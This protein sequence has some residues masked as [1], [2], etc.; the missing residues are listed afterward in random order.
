MADVALYVHVVF[1]GI[2]LI[3]GAVALTLTKGSPFHRKSGYV[4]AVTMIIMAVP[5]LVLS[6]MA[7][8]PFDVLSSLVTFYMVL[9]GLFSF[10]SI[11]KMSSLALVGVAGLCLAGYLTVEFRAL[12]FDVRATDAPPGAGYIFATVLAL[13]I[14]GDFKRLYSSE[15]ASHRKKKIRHLW[16]MN[17]ALLIATG[18][19]FGARPHL[20]PEWMQSSGAL[21]L[22]SLSLIHI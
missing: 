4:F 14:W 16:R 15:S 7:G 20:F 17:F 1:A 22:M 19:F 8:K 10:R 6:Y 2:G 12:V 9:T 11:S 13:A 3:T 21:V 18:S 5:A